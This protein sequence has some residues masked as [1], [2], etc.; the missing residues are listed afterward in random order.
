MSSSA[1]PAEAMRDSYV[2]GDARF[3]SVLYSINGHMDEGQ[4]AWRRDPVGI[5]QGALDLV[6]ACAAEVTSRQNSLIRIPGSKYCPDQMFVADQGLYFIKDDGQKTA[7][8][9]RMRHPERRPEVP[10]A[11]RIMLQ[12]GY[13]VVE[14]RDYREG[15]GDTLF[16]MNHGIWF[17]GTGKRTA[18]GAGRQLH[19]VSGRP[20]IEI[21]TIDDHFY[22]LDT[23]LSFLPK[24]HVVLYKDA[25]TSDAHK[26]ICK[27]YP[28]EQRLE[29]DR[30]AA[31]A[32]A[33]NIQIISDYRDGTRKDVLLIPEEAPKRVKNQ[34]KKWGYDIV[35][36]SVGAALKAGG[37]IHCSLQRIW[38]LR[39]FPQ[40]ALP[41]EFIQGLQG[42]RGGVSG[43][44]RTIISPNGQAPSI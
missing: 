5:R 34:L 10:H 13:K 8:M 29:I 44:D 20:V 27:L 35:E 4:K 40:Q 42:Y 28:P 18:P 25:M 16:D 19:E 32:L 15:S 23:F 39:Q 36:V 22:H 43:I 24:G 17:T 21:P 2:V 41:P 9:S 7:L 14:S 31:M 30:N 12:Q 33:A 37:G 26:L 38:D 3:F 6:R 1:M 11:R